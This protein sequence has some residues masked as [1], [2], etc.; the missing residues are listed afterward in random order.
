M[1]L[2]VP[3]NDFIRFVQDTFLGCSEATEGFVHLLY[4]GADH[5]HVYVESDGERSPDDMARDIKTVSA[6][7]IIEEFP[8]LQDMLGNGV[9]LWDEAYFVETVG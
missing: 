6:K 3:A 9:G 4:L 1:P 7:A 8:S 5:V 2:F